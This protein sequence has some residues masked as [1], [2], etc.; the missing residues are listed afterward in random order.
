M[1]ATILPT[2]K[3]L[4]PEEG[5]VS[6]LL[7]VTTDYAPWKEYVST[8]RASLEKIH[9]VEIQ[10]GEGGVLLHYDQ[11]L[12]KGHYTLCA[13]HGVTLSASDEEGILYAVATALQCLS[14]KR[15]SLVCDKVYVEDHPDKSYRAL[16][17]DLAREWH[18]PY[19]IHKFIDVCFMLKVKYL[20]LH[21]I[22]DQRYTLPSHV[23]PKLNDR[24]RH[25]TFEQIEEMRAYAHARGIVIIPEFEAPGHARFMVENYPEIFANHME[26]G[27]DATLVTENGDVIDAGNILCAGSK[28]CEEAI[29]L[30]LKEICDMF[31]DSPYIH[32][33]G[34]EAN[35]KA[36]NS[37]SLCTQYMKEHEIDGVYDLYSEFVGRVAQMVLDLGRTPIVWEGFPK[38]GAWRVPKE[39]VVIAWE[40]HYH[41][42][43]D[44]LD[45]GFKII[46]GSWKPLYIVPSYK[47]G[48]WATEEI[49]AWNVYNWQHWWVNSEATLN[50]IHVA[51]TDQLLGAQLS[52]WECSYEQEI[53]RVMEN[54]SALS[55]RTWNLRRYWTDL[56]FHHRMAAT[57]RKICR[58]IQD[59]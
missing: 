51:P 3:L 31:P 32:I 59:V 57:M 23:L 43:Q 11:T 28:Q 52:S 37:C 27:S 53:S 38:Q 8:L 55:E 34:D 24:C 25:Y 41:L 45:A 15:D 22:D 5:T 18:A 48:R 36:W 40:S 4:R 39:T 17:V 2:P 12:A 16:M 6:L 47:H 26:S 54:L 42:A 14:V 46:N 44:L 33:G 19:T 30:L 35:I 56:E 50:P 49:L 1:A 7:T 9:E 58:L 13:D 29:R 10:E 20:H 21:F